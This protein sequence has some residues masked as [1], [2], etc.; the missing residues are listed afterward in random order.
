MEIEL[1][2]QRQKRFNTHHVGSQVNAKNGDDTQGLR[3]ADYDEHEEGC[4]LR[5]VTGQCVSDGLL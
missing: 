5:N 1:N 3:D 2:V 4:D